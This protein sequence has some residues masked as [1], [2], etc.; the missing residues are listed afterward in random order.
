M[1][2]QPTTFPLEVAAAMIQVPGGKREFLTWLKANGYLTENSMPSQMAITSHLIFCSFILQPNKR[3]KV[4][5]HLTIKALGHF[6]KKLNRGNYIARSCY[7][8]PYTNLLP[9]HQ[10]KINYD[11]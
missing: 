8:G 3:Y 5:L 4:Q 1:H 10:D 11:K 7:W 2:D 9:S 6:S